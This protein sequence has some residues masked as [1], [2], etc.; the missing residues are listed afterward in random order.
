M[1]FGTVPLAEA[2]GLISAHTVR[3][4]DITL[5]KGAVIGPEEAAGLARTGLS[6]IVVAALDPG[7]V[8]EDDAAARLA[9]CLR[10]ANLR[11]E[12]PFTGR[13]NLFAERPGVLT[14][15]PTRIE[16]VNA[17]DEAV[18]VATL[19]RFR[20]VIEGE[21]IATV[22]IIPYA[23]PGAVLARACAA[24]GA[25]ALAV[26]TY[27]RR[28]VGVVSTR[29]PSL[30]EATIDKTLRVLAERLAPTGAAIV[31]EAR[32][33]HTDDAVA[34]AVTDLIDRAGADLVVVFGASAIADR[35]D[36]IPA[37]I[38]AAGGHVAHLGMPVDPGN[39]LLV[40]A[41][42]D[43]PVVGAPG[44]ARS[45][46]ENG[47]DWILHRLLAD[48]A[49]TRADIVALG[50]GGLLMEIVSRPQPRAG[51]AVT[52]DARDPATDD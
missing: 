14:L 18:T 43:V 2:G 22:K 30:K 50:V 44:C 41:R 45:P 7:D 17:V 6:E 1:R 51:G 31:A 12:S 11:V 28:R 40:G 49:V 26:A 34:A 37:G 23:V 52:G 3:R 24:A 27:R 15:D 21:M 20:P 48:L 8:G 9:G 5:R 38:E 25:D 46:K 33:P 47:F 42:G 36:V 19:P 35:R 4:A 29:L 16:A 13:C 39:L 32:I 10:G